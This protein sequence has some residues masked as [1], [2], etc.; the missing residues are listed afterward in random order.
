MDKNSSS[1]IRG[2]YYALP[3]SASLWIIIILII[4]EVTKYI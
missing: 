2:L 1:F 4:Q 3:M